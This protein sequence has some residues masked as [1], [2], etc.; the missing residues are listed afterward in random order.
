MLN[1]YWRNNELIEQSTRAVQKYLADAG[2]YATETVVGDR[3]LHNVLP[4]LQELRNL[5]AGYATRAVPTST[6]A[7]FGMSQW[8]QSASED[9]YRVGLERLF[10]PRLAFRLEE[11]LDGKISDPGK[12]YEAL[13][14]YLML[15]GLHPAD[16]ELIKSWMERDWA[17]NL[18][19]GVA[20]AQGR[21]LLEEHL[22]AMLDL[23][24]GSPLFTPNGRLIE[25]SQKALA[26]LN[27]AERA[28]AILKSQA[29][30]STAG[31]WVA[32]R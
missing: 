24:T 23:E 16:R 7:K 17:D 12:L 11:Q 26:R 10:R 19:P 1:S 27:V 8:L 14:V 18:Y 5:P 20:N 30:T 15:A 22:D 28:Y 13:K 32:A 4:L 3:D 25:E 2:P 31:D 29:R 6:F 21:K 9:A